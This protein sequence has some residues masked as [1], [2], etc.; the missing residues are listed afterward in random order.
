VLTVCLL[1]ACGLG[2]ASASEQA[3]RP[4]CEQ[5][6]LGDAYVAS[7]NAA[8]RSKRDLWGNRVLARPHGPTF[9]DVQGFLKPLLLV[10]RPAGK[11]GTRLTDSGVYYVPMGEPGGRSFADAGAVEPFALHVADGSQIVSRRAN[12]RQATVLVGTDG[13]ERYG[14]CL[15]R[16]AT[17]TLGDGYLPVLATRYSDAAGVQY[18]QESF[19][20]R[21]PR[22][23]TLA[24][25]VRIEAVHGTSTQRATE[26]LVDVSDSPLTAV[27]NDLR[28]AGRTVLAF[29]RGGVLDRDGLLRYRLD[30]TDGEPDVVYLVRPI[31]PTRGR[32]EAD[33]KTHAAARASSIAAWK[34]RLG[35][36]AQIEVPERLVMDAMR[37]L[38]VQNLQLAWRYSLG[39]AYETF[40]QPESS[41]AVLGLAEYGFSDDAREA[42]EALLPRSHGRS[43]NWE[44]GEKLAAGAAYYLLTGDAAFIREHSPTYVRYA[45]D[46][47]TRRAANPDGSGLLDAQRYSSDLTEAVYGLHHQS[48]AWRG[49]RD[50]AYVWGLV[51]SNWLATKYRAEAR[52]FGSSLRAAIVGSA[53]VVSDRETFVPVS[54]LAEPR[55]APW[56]PVTET[57][58][59]SYWNLVA[60]YGWA[61]GIMPRT[62]APA[63]TVLEY[64]RRRG[65]FLL[66]LVRFDYYPTRVGKVRCDGL[67]GLK[68]PG[69]NEAYA[70]HH[71]H[72]LADLDKPDLLVLALYAQLAHG[73]TRGTFIAGE[74]ATIG[75]VPPGAC[76][77]TP[78][79]EYYRSMYLPPSSASNDSFLTT[80]RESLAHWVVDDDG[81]PTGLRLADSTPR[82]WLA[83]GKRIAVSRL[84]TPFGR[85]S[86]SIQS[87]IDDGY[88]DAVL[89][90]PRRRP[91]G[92][93]RLRVRVPR[94]VRVSSA[95]IGNVTLRPDGETF[96]LTRKT[97]RLKLRVH[98]RRVS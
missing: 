51:G 50:M 49:L 7:V 26:I 42:L 56:D 60:P 13:A 15:A 95:R 93:L 32:L 98:V 65:S 8:L 30:L 61:S 72:F 53:T 28:S 58:E 14:S 86:F 85:L 5:P 37:N 18:V 77:Q 44:Q 31:D 39:N 91:I 78:D 76:P 63:R 10:G 73:M 81:R 69:L 64:A 25:Y 19:V 34:R 96:D 1:A 97:G 52:S 75:P 88:L 27:G 21:D 84:P 11:R 4:R 90:V 89:T 40:Y 94:S 54:L 41:A 17:P 33:A 38:L 3:E 71:V 23:G 57:R 48:R 47:A 83:D 9:P 62:G 2:V 87:H 22:T 80:L 92:E 12:G 29:R 20:A 43:T 66:G 82:G 70:V 67:P 46:F 79:G 35:E 16:L 68:T 6:R 59:G 24:S 55:E 45:R 36:G 74:G